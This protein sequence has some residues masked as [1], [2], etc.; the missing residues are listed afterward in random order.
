MEAKLVLHC[1]HLVDTAIVVVKVVG[2][3]K[4]NILPKSP[5]KSVNQFAKEMP[6]L[7]YGCL[8]PS[9]EQARTLSNLL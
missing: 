8:L 5:P 1:A 4:K 9:I 3:Q 2:P 7:A 6:T